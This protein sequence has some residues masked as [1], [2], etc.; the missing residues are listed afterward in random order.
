VDPQRQASQRHTGQG[1]SPRR[2]L[3]RLT[4][5]FALGGQVLGLGLVL[6]GP[7]VA[8]WITHGRVQVGTALM[9]SF[10][11]LLF[12]QA[13]DYPASM[14][15]TDAAGLRFQATRA[16]VMAAAN[17]ALSV[18]LAC[19]LGAPGPVLAS[20]AAYAVAVAAPTLRRALSDA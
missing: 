18:P 16:V 13:L 19:L 20:F 10:A 8:T 11:A 2:R 17:L 15:L 12:V 6:A 5:A 9:L 7:A 3:L 4:A 1:P 14:W